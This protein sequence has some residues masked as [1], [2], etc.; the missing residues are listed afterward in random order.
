MRVF[1]DA[2]VLISAYFID[3]VAHEMQKRILAEHELVL[4]L[5]VAEETAR[6]LTTKMKAPP[7]TV[8]LYLDDL[9]M[10]AAHVE[11]IPLSVTPRGL[12]DAND[13]AVLASALRGRADVL[14]TRDKDLLEESGR[15]A[16]EIT[17]LTPRAFLEI[18]QEE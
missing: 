10:R 16:D 18:I 11:P 8:S 3:T 17:I 5:F 7:A 1:P 14:V 12:R 9:R 15:F 4:G 13:E 6:V 2:N